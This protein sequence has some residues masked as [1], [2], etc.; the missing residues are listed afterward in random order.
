MFRTD[1]VESAALA[2]LSG[3]LTFMEHEKFR[4]VSLKLLG[5]PGTKVT[6]DFS[7]VD[8]IDSAGLGMLL[9]FREEMAGAGRSLCLA[10]AKGQV[11][12]MFSL[13]KFRSL[14][15]IIG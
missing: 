10:N 14:F 8:F 3:Q 13:S 12:R 2:Q 6:L 11:S 15:E 4:D 9:F 5:V 7:N 1:V